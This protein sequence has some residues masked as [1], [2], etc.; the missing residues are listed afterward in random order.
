MNVLDLT[1]D[2]LKRAVAL[3]EQIDKLNKELGS[4][5]GGS[6]TSRTAPKKTPTV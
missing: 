2:R 1:V 6:A 5:L 3:K 4:I